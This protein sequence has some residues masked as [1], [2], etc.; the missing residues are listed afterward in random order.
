MHGLI[1][2][3]FVYQSQTRIKLDKSTSHSSSDGSPYIY[4]FCLKSKKGKF[5][6]IV[7]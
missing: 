1:M 5:I 2:P 6:R 7:N 4:L 3:T